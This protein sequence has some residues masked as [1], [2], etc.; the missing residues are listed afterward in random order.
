MEQIHGRFLRRMLLPI[1]ILGLEMGWPVQVAAQ[2]T[3]STHRMSESRII[4]RAD[5]AATYAVGG[6]RVVRLV[7]STNDQGR[8]LFTIDV[9]KGQ[10]LFR[11][12]VDPVTDQVL[13]VAKKY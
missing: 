2:V 8:T 4:V 6:G 5:S 12:V 11:V 9:Q 13:A 10:H 3:S 7:P 1:M